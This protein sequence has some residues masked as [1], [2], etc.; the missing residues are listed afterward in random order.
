MRNDFDPC[1][2]LLTPLQYLATEEYSDAMRD[3]VALA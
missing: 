1:D 3:T 2:I